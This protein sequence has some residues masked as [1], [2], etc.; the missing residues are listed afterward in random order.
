[1]DIDKRILVAIS[2]I[3]LLI[4]AIGCGR[5]G[6]EKRAQIDFPKDANGYPQRDIV[7]INGEKYDL[8]NIEKAIVTSQ[9]KH[10]I[11][12]KLTGKTETLEVILPQ[13]NPINLW[14]IE[15]SKYMDLVSY[16]KE[17]VTIEN[18]DM[19]EGASV[20]LQKFRITIPQDENINLSFKWAN[21]NEIEKSFNDKVE[22]YLLTI[23]ISRQR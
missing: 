19:L 4:F 18:K 14:S 8:D 9:I 10:E 21:V 22:N 20:N 2:L 15:D 11:N 12:L 17:P 1:M 13:N 7:V 6:G 23:K 3:S 16:N 5:N